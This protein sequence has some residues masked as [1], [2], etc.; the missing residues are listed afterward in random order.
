MKLMRSRVLVLIYCSPRVRQLPSTRYSTRVGQA[1]IAQAVG[2]QLAA[3]CGSWQGR[4][5]NL[6]VVAWPRGAVLTDETPASARDP[7]LDHRPSPAL[8]IN[9]RP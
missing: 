5:R 7:R 2:L 8:S 1:Q 6:G 9:S 4:W 3:E